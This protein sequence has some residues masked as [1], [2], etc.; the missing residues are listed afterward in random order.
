MNV[1]EPR[2]QRREAEAVAGVLD[3]RAIVM[4]DAAPRRG[5]ASPTAASRRRPAKNM[6]YSA[7]SRFSSASSRLQVLLH[8]GRACRRLPRDE[9]PDERQPQVARV[10]HRPIV[11]EHLGVVRRRRR[12][13]NRS[14][15][16]AASLRPEPRAVAAVS[17]GARSRGTQPTR[18]RERER[19]A[20]TAGRRASGNTS[21]IEN[22]RG[23]APNSASC[24]SGSSAAS[25]SSVG[26]SG[27][28]AYG[29]NALER[30]LFRE[31]PRP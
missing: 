24:R 6:L 25:S 26:C 29:Q 10:R 30:S 18:A 9:E 2:L 13:G 23:C 1:G 28:S 20:R 15:S 27:S 31:D 22:G 19:L 12:S 7:S 21:V 5:R 16:L 4:L 11:D 17:A 3:V 14:R 8:A